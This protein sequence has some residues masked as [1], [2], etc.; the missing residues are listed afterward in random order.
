MAGLSAHFRRTEQRAKAKRTTSAV[1][2]GR[3][4]RVSDAARSARLPCVFEVDG[5]L[6]SDDC[7]AS[8][9]ASVASCGSA[10]DQHVLSGAAA[11][12][13]AA[14]GGGLLSRVWFRRVVRGSP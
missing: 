10:G 4:P 14:A 7:G 9:T 8:D 5:A 1:A 12:G 13:G 11:K 2:A 6:E 3:P